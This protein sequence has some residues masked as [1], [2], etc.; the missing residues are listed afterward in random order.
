MIYAVKYF[1]QVHVY[2]Y[3]RFFS[4]FDDCEFGDIRLSMPFHCAFEDRAEFN[5][6]LM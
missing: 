1:G 5:G 6:D 3:N 4:L 2:Q